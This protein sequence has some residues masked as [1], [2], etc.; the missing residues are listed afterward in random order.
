MKKVK[1]QLYCNLN[2]LI[3]KKKVKNKRESIIYILC[4]YFYLFL[5]KKGQKV[6]I[7]K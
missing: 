4:F 3:A 2:N 6:S 7:V 1:V 5:I